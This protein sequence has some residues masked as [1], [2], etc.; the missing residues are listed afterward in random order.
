MIKKLALAASLAVCGSAAQADTFNVAIDG[1][2]NTFQINVTG[3][4]V[5]GT[6]G[7]CGPAG[8]LGGSVARVDH[9]RG[10]VA[11]E[12]IEGIVVT[13]YFTTPVDGS[14]KVYVT[15]SN[16][17]TNAV[18]GAGTYHLVRRHAKQPGGDML[19]G[20]KNR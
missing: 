5:A 15:G 8:V 13:W 14:G 3:L 20:L 17:S 4:L 18:L 6:R 12:T 11:S 9:K 10:V 16:G 1:H 7:G 2:C 19:A